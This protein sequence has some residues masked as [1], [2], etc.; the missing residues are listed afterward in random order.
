M[1]NGMGGLELI[2]RQQQ[3]PMMGGDPGQKA[4]VFGIPSAGAGRAAADQFGAKGPATEDPNA[5]ETPKKSIWTAVQQIRAAFKKAD[6]VARRSDNAKGAMKQVLRLEAERLRQKAEN[7]IIAEAT[8][9]DAA[10]NETLIMFDR[11][12]AMGQQ[13]EFEA[14]E[15]PND[16]QQRPQDKG[17]NPKFQAGTGTG[18]FM[19]TTGASMR[20]QGYR[21]LAV[22]RG[23]DVGTDGP[24]KEPDGKVRAATGLGRYGQR[25][26]F[27]NGLREARMQGIPLNKVR[28]MNS[29]STGTGGDPTQSESFVIGA[30]M[31]ALEWAA[32]RVASGDTSLRMFSRFLRDEGVD[33]SKFRGLEGADALVRALNLDLDHPTELLREVGNWTEELLRELDL[34]AEIFESHAKYNFR[35]ALGGTHI[36]DTSLIMQGTERVTVP[37]PGLNNIVDA[38]GQSPIATTLPNATDISAL[39]PGRA[40]YDTP[41]EAAPAPYGVAGNSFGF[42]GLDG[43]VVYEIPQGLAF[44]TKDEAV[45]W[46]TDAIRSEARSIALHRATNEGRIPAIQY[47]ESD[48]VDHTAYEDTRRGYEEAEA[49]ARRIVAREPGVRLPWQVAPAWA[50]AQRVASAR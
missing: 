16:R 40:R 38:T 1:S 19:I 32:L 36:E 13:A 48:R 21:P 25:K 49:L 14:K 28:Q 31:E 22:V 9:D 2:R 11:V 43:F 26:V 34:D 15:F 6:D 47:Y 10:T 24:N 41:P 23:T 7:T 18:G 17:R 35:H 3:E 44:P 5:C 37:H 33:P 30:L 46:F 4:V 27:F 20:K 8:G 50:A 29:H 42:N 39:Q 12:G 45:R